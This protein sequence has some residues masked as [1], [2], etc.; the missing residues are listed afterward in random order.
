LEV[1]VELLGILE[2]LEDVVPIHE[3]LGPA[4]NGILEA[5]LM[6]LGLKAKLA[7]IQHGVQFFEDDGDQL[8]ALVADI[9]ESQVRLCQVV[10]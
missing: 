3:A 7:L 5:E 6:L 8:G 9:S 10:C 2:A 1:L 4:I